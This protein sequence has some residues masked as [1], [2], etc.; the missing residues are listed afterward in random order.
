MQKE[1]DFLWQIGMT[2]FGLSQRIPFAMMVGTGQ[3][4]MVLIP[5]KPTT[6]N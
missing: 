3:A 4:T 6:T 5:R 2:T 1:W